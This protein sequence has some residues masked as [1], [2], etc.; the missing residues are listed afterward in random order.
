MAASVTM[1]RIVTL[2]FLERHQRRGRAARHVDPDR[3]ARRRERGM[4]ERHAQRLAHDLRRRGGP[5][6]L[7]SAARRSARAASEIGRLLERDGAVHEPHAERLHLARIL[8]L[9]RHQRDAAGHQHRGQIVAGRER[10]HHRGQSLVARRD[11]EHAAPR[12]QRSNQPAE[13]RRRIVAER[14]AVEHRRRALRSA[15]ARIGARRRERNR[16]G[17]LEHTRRRFEQ[18]SD[19]PVTGVIPERDRRPIGRANAAV[20]REHQKLFAAERRRIPSHAGVLRPAEQIAGRPLAQHLR[21]QRQRARGSRRARGHIEQSRIVSVE[22]ICRHW[23]TSLCCRW[24]YQLPAPPDGPLAPEEIS[25]IRPLARLATLCV[26]ALIGSSSSAAA[27]GAGIKFGPD[28]RD[29]QQRGA[30]FRNPHRHS[31]RP[32]RRR[33]PRQGR[34]PPDRV[35]LAAEKGGDCRRTADPDR[36]PADSSAAARECRLELRERGCGATASSDRRSN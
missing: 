21:R 17:R 19:F 3:V 5:E 8:A 29:L 1:W 18:Q 16:A 20:R 32:L 2:C 4:S 34:R 10:H 23:C 12:R 9:L 7:T 14:Q 11:A 36:L 6:K 15:V 13:D 28:L 33:Q 26:L 27:Q 22:G 30:G 24:Y 31:R 25:M 35:Q